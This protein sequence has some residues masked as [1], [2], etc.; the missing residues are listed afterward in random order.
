MPS[1]RRLRGALLRLIRRRI[2]AVVVG[3]LLAVPAAWL[4]MSGRYAEWWVDGLCLVLGA[5]GVALVW[6]GLTGPRSDW[7]DES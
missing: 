7:I 5:T 1:F 6:A 4:E 2:V 3:L